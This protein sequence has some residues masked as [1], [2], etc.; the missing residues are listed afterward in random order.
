MNEEQ[1]ATALIFVS[2]EEAQHWPRGSCVLKRRVF[3]VDGNGN[4]QQRY[5]VDN[6]FREDWVMDEAKRFGN[7]SYALLPGVPDGSD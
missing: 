3:V 4:T 1:I 2:P 5:E 7:W 6:Y